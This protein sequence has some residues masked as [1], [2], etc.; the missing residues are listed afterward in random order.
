[1]KG[2]TMKKIVGILIV[3]G[4][5]VSLENGAQAETA[6][7]SNSGHVRSRCEEEQQLP[8]CSAGYHSHCCAEDEPIDC[9]K[10]YYP[11]QDY[12]GNWVCVRLPHNGH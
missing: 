8:L 12:N 5:L 1:M 3:F 6:D 2:L 4:T 11:M 9:G 10:F 7:N